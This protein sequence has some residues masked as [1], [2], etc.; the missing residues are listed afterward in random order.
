MFDIWRSGY[1]RRPLASVVAA[2][3]SADEIHWLPL[4]ESRCQYLADPFAQEVDGRVSVLVEAYDYRVRRGEIHYLSFDRDD[5][6]VAEGLALSERWHLSYP[7]L[8]EDGGQIY[9]LPEAH[10]SKALILYRCD[11][12]PDRWAPV[13]RLLDL[14]AIDA[15]VVKHDYRWWM[16]FTLPGR[17][18]RAMREMYVAVADSLMGP[19]R[20]WPTP[21]LT[22]LNR[23]RPGGQAFVRDGAIHLPVQDCSDTYGGALNLLRI[24][25][26]NPGGF[27]AIPVDRMEA[28]GLLSGF[29]D[30]LHTLSG[31]GSITCIDVKAFAEAPEEE[32]RFKKEARLRRYLGLNRARGVA[33]AWARPIPALFAARA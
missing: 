13:K 7:S 24:V 20:A 32:R 25:D 16:F 30:G 22:G 23:S 28:G 14:P 2:P 15:T 5:R 27:H 10:K 21:V 17:E 11:R 4:R 31:A 9:M 19:W 12:F 33:N 6:L 1:I 3:P 29:S 26:P 18:E 8:I